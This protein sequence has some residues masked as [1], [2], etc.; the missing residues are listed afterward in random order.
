MGGVTIR[1]VC[2]EATI[3]TTLNALVIPSVGHTMTVKGL[4]FQVTGIVWDLNAPTGSAVTAKLM[5]LKS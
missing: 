5:Q 4:L 3:V 2:L 1:W